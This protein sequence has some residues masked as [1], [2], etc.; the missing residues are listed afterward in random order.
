MLP[1]IEADEVLAFA[2]RGVLVD[3]RNP[4]RF[5]GEVEPVDPVAGH[6]PGAVNVPTGTNLR[7]DGTFRPA[8]I[9]ACTPQRG[10]R[11]E[12]GVYCGS[13]S[14]R[15]RRPGAGDAG[16]DGA[17]P[18]VVERVG[19]RPEPSG[20]R[21]LSSRAVEHRDGAMPTTADRRPERPHSA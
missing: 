12:V 8:E 9:A 16:I 15:P 19:R 21:S 6:I 3:A 4:E 13:G 7:A 18:G 17:V 5:R 14:P 1:V 11:G 10:H 2:E 20:R